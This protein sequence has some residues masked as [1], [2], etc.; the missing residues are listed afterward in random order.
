MK[1]A[2][3]Y[4]NRILLLVSGSSPAIITETLY[5][6]TQ[7]VEPAFIPTE[8]YIIT[9]SSG[10]NNIQRALLGKAGHLTQLCQSYQLPPSLLSPK[11]CVIENQ[12]GELLS[13][14]VSAE[15]NE[16]CANFIT[17]KMRELTSRD[18]VSLHVSIAGGRKTMTYYL[19]YAMSV[20]GRIQDQMSHVLVDENYISTDFYY[21][22]PQP[23]M[24]ETRSGEK[25]D[26]SQVE[27]KLAQ[28]PYLRL[29]D[30]L[31]ED[32]LNNKK[33]SY[34][35]LIALAQQQLEPIFVEM[36]AD[37]LRCGGQ[38]IKLSDIQFAVYRWLLVRHQENQPPVNF[39]NKEGRKNL[40][41]DF[42]S[43]YAEIVNDYSGHYVKA[44]EKLENGMDA[45]YFRPHR[46]R[47]NDALKRVLG[48]S[49]A[50]PYLI[51]SNGSRNK[52]RYSLPSGLPQDKIT[53]R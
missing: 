38:L 50:E 14:I 5:A 43:V 2:H 20:F 45:D 52:M 21:P 33:R 49:G 42:L 11:I 47:T 32:L 30:G 53:F 25:F 15:D 34:S 31:T 26:A 29:R 46:T 27:V 24:M 8:I 9:T 16:A 40:A 28:L 3:E 44:E 37:T 39:Q 13:D 19:G 23:I 10:K 6:I 1:Q 12:Q 51:E 7:K 36:T 22:P 17:N 18:N 48:Q 41:K 35:D 4:P